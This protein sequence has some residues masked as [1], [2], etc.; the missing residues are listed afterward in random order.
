V[1]SLELVVA[2]RPITRLSAT[3]F[4]HLWISLATPRAAAD[5]QAELGVFGSGV[6]NLWPTHHLGI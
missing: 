5:I 2:I 4:R 1:K 3:N 6:A